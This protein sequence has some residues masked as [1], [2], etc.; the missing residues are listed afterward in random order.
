[1][2]KYNGRLK[3]KHKRCC[4]DLPELNSPSIESSDSVQHKEGNL[5]TRR[6]G[7]A[8]TNK[9]A[10]KEDR[11]VSEHISPSCRFPPYIEWKRWYSIS[12]VLVEAGYAQSRLRFVVTFPHVFCLATHHVALET[13]SIIMFLTADQLLITKASLDRACGADCGAAAAFQKEFFSFTFYCFDLL[14]IC[15]L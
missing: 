4:H 9:R 2:R 8:R 6:T 10:P 13:P 3:R 14:F 11:Q 1:M 12:S 15:V 5:E 7:G